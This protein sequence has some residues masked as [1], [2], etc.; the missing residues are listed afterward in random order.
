MTTFCIFKQKPDSH[1]HNIVLRPP[2]IG[3]KFLFPNPL[4]YFISISSSWNVVELVGVFLTFS[5]III[6]IIFVAQ[7]SDDSYLEKSREYK[8]I[9]KEKAFWDYLFRPCKVSSMIFSSNNY[10]VYL[11]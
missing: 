6:I 9:W 4:F 8:K 7:H 11:L 3:I 10:C 5:I 2:F 1:S